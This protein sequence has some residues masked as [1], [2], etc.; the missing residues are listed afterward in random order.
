MASHE[1]TADTIIDAT[2]ARV[3]E[4]VS[5][6][7]RVQDWMPNVHDVKPLGAKKGVGAERSIHLRIGNMAILSHQKVTEHEPGKRFA[8]VHT[9]DTIDGK[10]FDFLEDLGTSFGLAS[11]GKST[12]VTATMHFTPKGLKAKIAMPLVT[13]DVKKQMHTALANLKR[14]AE[15]P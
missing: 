6:P 15:Q 9:Q 11:K 3:F 5:D 12:H 7:R 14:L 8:W 10:P 1:I 4:I 2:A 13:K